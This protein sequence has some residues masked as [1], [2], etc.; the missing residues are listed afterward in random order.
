MLR[1]YHL[2]IGGILLVIIPLGAKLIFPNFLSIEDRESPSVN[3]PN[4]TVVSSSSRAKTTNLKPE[5]TWRKL[6]N[7]SNSVP[8]SW[9]I[10]PCEE[11]AVL[12]CVAAQGKRLG[13]VELHIEL[14]KDNPTLKKYLTEAGIPVDSKVDYQ[15]P[16]SQIK[17]VKALQ[18]W[19]GDSYNNLAK[20][21]QAKDGNKVAFSTY[22]PQQVTIGKL[23]GIR[24]GF[25]RLQGGDSVQEQYIGYVTCDG[26]KLYVIS[27]SFNGGASVAKFDRLEDLAIFQPYLSAIAEN[28]NLP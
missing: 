26:T 23:P 15:N 17:L 8:D 28:L 9:Q 24:Y 6:L 14:V 19:V 4:K 5:N 7:N 20:Q 22:P 27:T 21:H 11:N 13:T 18:S 1:V 16:Q 2:I 10:T 25:V 3:T 12:L